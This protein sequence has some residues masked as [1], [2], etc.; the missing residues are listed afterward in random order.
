MAD[1][2]SI[3]AG[4]ASLADVCIRLARFL[5]DANDG[6]RVVDQ[7]LEDLFK[8]I[9]SLQSVNESIDELVK[10]SYP[11]G[12][13]ARTNPHLGKIL[14]TNWRATNNTLSSCQ[15]IV[16]RIEAILKDV[17]NAGSGKHIKRDQVRKWLKQ[18][19]KEEELSTLREKLKAHQLALQLSLSAVGLLGFSFV[20]QEPVG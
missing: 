14:D 1:P 4:V 8:E 16:E 17:V 9:A 18:Q 3:L 11:E 6:F 13:T 10:R 7:E 2:F 15:L 12:S 20:S 19:S 5:K